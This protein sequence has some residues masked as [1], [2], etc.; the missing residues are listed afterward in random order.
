MIISFLKIGATGR[1][2]VVTQETA[3]VPIDDTFFMRMM[4]ERCVARH[5][6]KSGACIAQ[7]RY[8]SS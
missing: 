1:A 8:P 7:L 2:R 4:P 3:P 6:N 5:R